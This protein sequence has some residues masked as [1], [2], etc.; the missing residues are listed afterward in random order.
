MCRPRSV[1][2]VPVLLEPCPCRVERS[3]CLT[4]VPGQPRRLA[5]AQEHRSAPIVGGIDEVERGREVC[6][7]LLE[8]EGLER[9][10]GGAK[11]VTGTALAVAALGEMVG[12]VGEL[13][14]VRRCFMRLQCPP[15]KPV[16]T[17][18]SGRCDFIV[19]TFANL[20]VAEAEFACR[21]GVDQPGVCCLS[22]ALLGWLRFV[23][24]RLGQDLEVKCSADNGGSLQRLHDLWRQATEPFAHRS[25]D[26][27]RNRQGSVR[28]ETNT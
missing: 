22:Q 2:D 26:A 7:C 9:L 12:E 20:V 19:E 27:G 4:F 23:T 8:G 16:Q 15:N 3:Y 6:C 1:F 28:D 10:L 25:D 5:E 24:D 21:T 14:R 18:P 13:P 11:R 17:L